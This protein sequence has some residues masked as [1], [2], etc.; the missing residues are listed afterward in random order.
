ML[1][2]FGGLGDWILKLVALVM[3]FTFVELIL[4][5]SSLGKYVR[6]VM[7][8]FVILFMIKPLVSLDV[9]KFLD[10]SIADRIGI[11]A[12]LSQGRDSETS[13]IVS[14]GTA[15][16]DSSMLMAT[17]GNTE[18]LESQISATLELLGGIKKA[19]VE[20]SEVTNAGIGST[21]LTLDISDITDTQVNETSARIMKYLTNTYGVPNNRVTINYTKGES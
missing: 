5:D 21:K 13:E 8:F 16:R 19:E 7:G 20:I 1:E 2:G 14:A 17:D 18:L 9:P 4:P 12:D 10:G 11:L 15:L 3:F 6:L